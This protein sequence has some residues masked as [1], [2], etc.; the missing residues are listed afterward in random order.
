MGAGLVAPNFYFLFMETQKL[1]TEKGKSYWAKDGAYNEI[2]DLK[3]ETLVPSQGEA[4]TIHGELVRCFGRLNYEFGNNGNCNCLA[5]INTICPECDGFGYEEEECSN[6]QGN[7][8]IDEDGDECECSDCDGK[9]I[10]EADCQWCNGD[11]NIDGDF[12][13]T[14]NY[15][16]FL[17]FLEFNLI[18]NSSF[19][20]L[21]DFLLDSDKGYSNYS[22]DDDEMSIYN[23]V[24]DAVGWQISTTENVNI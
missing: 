1:I 7:G 17:S 2:M 5:R 20:R 13:I 24:G 16:E 4:N 14:P 22:F 6:C 12:F 9:G 8:V 19:D 10:E 15:E 21:R 3:W 11:C 18:D 23:A